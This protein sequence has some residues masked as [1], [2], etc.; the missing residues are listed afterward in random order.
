MCLKKTIY[1]CTNGLVEKFKYE[2]A[3]TIRC[4][5]LSTIKEF[6]A[7]GLS[8]IKEFDAFA[9]N[10]WLCVLSLCDKNQS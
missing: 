7:F 3:H 5:G 6:D 4:C 10:F 1:I 2:T 9:S 8:T